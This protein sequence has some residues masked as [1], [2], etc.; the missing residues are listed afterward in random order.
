MRATERRCS[1]ATSSFRSVAANTLGSF[2][3]WPAFPTSDYYDPSAPLRQHQRATRLPAD[4][5]AALPVA[6]FELTTWGHP[7]VGP[8]CYAKAGKAIY[9]VP[10]RFIGQH[11]DARIGERT[12]EFYVDAEIIKT[13]VK[14]EKCK[15]TDWTDFPPEKVAFF[16]S[17]PQWCLKQATE[18]GEYVKS[19]VTGLLEVNALYRL[20]QA[21]GVIRLADKHGAE[22]LDTTGRRAIEIGD[23]EYRTVKG[24]L[25][26]GTE[27]DG[28][29]ASRCRSAV[30]SSRRAA[31]FA[32]RV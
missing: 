30:A 21:Q 1:S 14:V 5:L 9:T 22:R 3:M 24:I 26:A 20:R 12:V 19:L 2:A 11:V 29:V 18:L 25:V 23:P 15:Q 7:K 10:W 17:T 16:M 6:P 8:D 4:Q 27:N 28:D 13:W 32:N 31:R